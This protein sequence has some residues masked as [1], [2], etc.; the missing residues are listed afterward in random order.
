VIDLIILIIFTTDII[1]SFVLGYYTDKG[2]LVMD[3][4]A[5]AAHYAK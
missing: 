5:I 1:I 2:E 4:R 3:H